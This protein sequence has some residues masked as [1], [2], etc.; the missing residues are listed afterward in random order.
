MRKHDYPLIAGERV[1]TGAPSVSCV[2]A[3]KLRLRE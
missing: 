3:I 1:F 2:P